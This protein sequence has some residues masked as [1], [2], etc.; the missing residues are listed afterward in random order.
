MVPNVLSAPTGLQ[1]AR[2]IQLIV[3][4]TELLA[5]KNVIRVAIGNGQ[6]ADVK[7]FKDAGQILLL[8]KQAGL[9]DLRVWRKDGKED[10]R[11]IR[12][13][14]RP[15]AEVLREVEMQL[16]GIEGVRA[17]RAGEHVIVEG[18]SIRAQDT[19]R[20]DAIAKRNPSVINAVSGGGVTMRGMIFLDVKVVEV[21]KT[22]LK[23]IGVDWNDLIAGPTYANLS[24]F[25]SNPYYRGT[26]APVE[27]GSSSPG[28]PLDV[29]RNN[30]Y[31][32]ISTR[33]TSMINL[34]AQNGEAR[35]LAEPKLTC[36]SGGKAE[37][38][39][40]GEV[41]IP[42]TDRQG[43]LNVLFKQYGIILRMS[44]TSDPLGYIDTHVEV[45]VST[46]D[47]SVT[48]LGIPGFL[49][50]KTQTD[51]NV[52]EGQTMVISGLFTNERSKDVNKVPGLGHLPILGELFKSRQF[53]NKQTELVVLVTPHLVH[54]DSKSN[55]DLIRHAQ[56]MRKSS[57]DTMRFN[58]LD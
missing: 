20:V 32:G 6:L 46:I 42:I 45:E 15:P 10:H 50:R 21:K 56:E 17:R 7:V 36:R 2:T 13:S 12:I 22:D 25:Q 24:D 33:I 14:T 26:G 35:M 31:F 11:I 51:M 30:P 28:L 47:P 57:K 52:R 5:Y 55:K 1:Q 23:R 40:G 18:Q 53:Q 8:G 37:F 34:L 49:S 41:P 44:P 39:A 19:A 38:L 29:G 4:Q 9:T 43:A 27:T 16:R 58:L 48:V 54:A 3:G